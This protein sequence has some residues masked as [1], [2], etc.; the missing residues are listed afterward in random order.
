MNRAV[1]VSQGTFDAEVLSA[2]TPVVVSWHAVAADPVSRLVSP[3]ID[4][5]MGRFDGVKYVKVDAAG[6]SALAWRWG[7]RRVPS[8]AF[9]KEGRMVGPATPVSRLD[10]LTARLE[11]L[12]TTP[13]AALP[14]ADLD[15]VLPE[16]PDAPAAPPVPA[17]LLA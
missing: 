17:A 3:L 16:E 8:L 6:E 15:P 2:E 1:Q 11:Q 4:E 13:I 12:T 5:L 14:E 9:F 7:V 10:H